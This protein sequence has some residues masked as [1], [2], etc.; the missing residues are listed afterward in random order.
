MTGQHSTIGTPENAHAA[1]ELDTWRLFGDPPIGLRNWS[2]CACEI[3]PD[4]PNRACCADACLCAYVHIY[5][6]CRS[7][8]TTSGIWFYF[9]FS[10]TVAPISF[11]SFLRSSRRAS[12]N[13]TRSVIIAPPHTPNRTPDRKV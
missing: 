6:Q 13:S 2:L 4:L 12:M 7:D 10:A 3:R 5:S 1:T 11:S 8:C 9:Y